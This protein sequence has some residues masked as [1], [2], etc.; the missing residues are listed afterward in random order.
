MTTIPLT[1]DQSQVL[2]T[3][4]QEAVR[5]VDLCTKK[6]YVLLPKET[7]Q[8]LQHLLYEDAP[9]DLKEAYPL[10]DEVAAKA[11]WNDPTMDIYNE[12]A[13]DPKP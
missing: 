3:Q 11:G 13:P 9:F 5:M 8:R 10:M 2:S 1:S 7:Y 4:E 6:A 12:L